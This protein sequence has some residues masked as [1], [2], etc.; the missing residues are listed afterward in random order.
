VLVSVY[1]VIPDGA[2]G[3]LC[4]CQ[5]PAAVILIVV[6]K[7]LVS[8]DVNEEGSESFVGAKE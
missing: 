7:R 8:V 4:G 3:R 6:V 5:A 2:F 1:L